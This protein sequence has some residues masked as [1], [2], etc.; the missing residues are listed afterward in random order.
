[1]ARKCWVV[2]FEVE[3][4]GGS[5]DLNA[6][7]DPVFQCLGGK[8]LCVIKANDFFKEIIL[9]PEKELFFAQ[10][11]AQDWPTANIINHIRDIKTYMTGSFIVLTVLHLYISHHSLRLDLCFLFLHSSFK[12]PYYEYKSKINDSIVQH[13]CFLCH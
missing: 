3:E 9:T 4:G 6:H 5:W 2:F 1:M 8:S 11:A 13:L 7:Y 10:T 12:L